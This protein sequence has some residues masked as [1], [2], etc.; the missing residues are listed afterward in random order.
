MLPAYSDGLQ[1]IERQTQ[2]DVGKACMVANAVSAK[3]TPMVL[4]LS[5][6]AEMEG[7]VGGQDCTD[8]Q[9]PD[10]LQNRGQL[11]GLLTCM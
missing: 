9:F 11:Q 10:F 1:F 4:E 5:G 8:D 6:E 7:H 3:R 2:G